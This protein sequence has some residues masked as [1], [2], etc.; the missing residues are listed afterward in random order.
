MVWGLCRT[1]G[2]TVMRIVETIGWAN[3]TYV[4]FT[5]RRQA[6]LIRVISARDMSRKERT[7]YAQEA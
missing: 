1:E 7:H 4:T 3:H 2:A 6:T 5:P